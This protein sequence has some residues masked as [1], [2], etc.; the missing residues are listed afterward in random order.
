MFSVGVAAL[1]W[2]SSILCVSVA[3]L[4]AFLMCGIMSRKKHVSLYSHFH[5]TF[6][7]LGAGGGSPA[8]S[9]AT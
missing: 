9:N 2:S 5:I 7:S 3:A 1:F 4:F 8:T 6:A